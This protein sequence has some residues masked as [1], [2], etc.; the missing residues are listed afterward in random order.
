MSIL[1]IIL[2]TFLFL[3]LF[4]S[5]AQGQQISFELNDKA[6]GFPYY[7]YLLFENDIY[8][9][10]EN[11]SCESIFLITNNGKINKDKVN[12]CHFVFF[13]E[14]LETT[15]IYINK[16]Q[17]NDTFLVETKI[18]RIRLWPFTATINGYYETGFNIPINKLANSSLVL[19]SINTGLSAKATIKNL[20]ITIFRNSDLIYNK[21]ISE[22]N[23][24]H[25]FFSE[26]ELKLVEPGD[27]IMYSNICYQYGEYSFKAESISVKIK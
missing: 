2:K 1:Q 14:K 19:T 10:I 9:A 12:K 22:V 8:V 24:T 3:I 25:R 7:A 21:L 20:E 15:N 18:I 16:I 27:I 4:I 11:E 17:E 13:P 26:E 23:S 5:S 6:K